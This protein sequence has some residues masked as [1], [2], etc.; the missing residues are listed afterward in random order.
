MAL[1][2]E[3][4]TIFLWISHEEIRSH[5]LDILNRSGYRALNVETEA[6]LFQC[7]SRTRRGVVFV[8]SG[9]IHRYGPTLYARIRQ[10][11]GGCRVI[12]LCSRESRS[13][14]REAME[15]GVYGCV[16]EPY[17]TWEIQTMVRHILADFPDEATHPPDGGGVDE[18]KNLQNST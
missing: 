16:V 5:V 15:A 8:D 12:L 13:L 4:T 17:A 7:L 18:H 9:M 2:N 14:I 1:K 6:D 3:P 11:C 10:A